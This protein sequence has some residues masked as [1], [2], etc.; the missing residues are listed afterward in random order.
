MAMMTDGILNPFSQQSVG[1][2]LPINVTLP[3]R[4]IERYEELLPILRKYF[5][6][7]AIPGILANIDVETDGTFDFTK[8]QN[9]GGPGYGLFQF[10]DQKEAYFEWLEASARRDTPESQIKFVADAIYNDDYNAKGMF[11]GPLDIGGESRKAIRK[12]FTKGSPASI[13]KVFSDEYEKPSV[14]HNDRRIESAI[15]LEKKLKEKPLSPKPATGMMS[16]GPKRR[17]SRGGRKRP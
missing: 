17:G 14:P 3:G 10:D 2:E 15:R 12:S 13:A 11:T 16:S 8:Q 1:G 7:R 6:E 4:K 9:K 5:P